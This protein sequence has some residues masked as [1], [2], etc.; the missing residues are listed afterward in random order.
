MDI[1]TIAFYTG[2]FISLWE[3][4]NP[5]QTNKQHDCCE[6]R[7]G[8]Y[9]LLSQASFYIGRVTELLQVN[10]WLLLLVTNIVM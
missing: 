5:H 7:R 10:K 8:T 2:T 3:S 4:K 6:S 1:I 9:D